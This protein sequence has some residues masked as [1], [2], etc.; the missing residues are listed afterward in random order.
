MTADHDVVRRAVREVVEA[1]PVPP[2][3]DELVRPAPRRVTPRRAMTLAVSVVAAVLVAV[4]LAVASHR[5]VDA[6]GSDS[7]ATAPTGPSDPPAV[8]LLYPIAG[9]SVQA[10]TVPGAATLTAATLISPSG[11]VFVVDAS[12]TAPGDAPTEG[13]T[14]RFN[15]NTV[16]VANEDQTLAY[17]TAVGCTKLAV[18]DRTANPVA[19]SPDATALLEAMTIADTNVTAQ[20]PRG[21]TSLGASPLPTSYQLQFTATVAGQERTASLYQM[22]DAPIGTVATLAASGRATPSRLGATPAWIF[23]RDGRS[24]ALAW[25]VDGRAAL[26]VVPNARPAQLLA[27][28]G[29]LSARHTQEWTAQLGQSGLPPSSTS[30]PSDCGP[31]SITLHPTG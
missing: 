27:L 13:E 19:W 21:W 30:T 20:M 4:V 8:R 24:I 7:P 6:P 14:R 9:R 31:H 23:T 3:F 22:L 2:P 16:A 15:G 25:A 18:G 5:S 26:L 12:D 11:G 10:A 1:A 29:Q 17:T 28:A